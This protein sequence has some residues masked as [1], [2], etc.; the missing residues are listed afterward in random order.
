MF[1]FY[2]QVPECCRRLQLC[3]RHQKPWGEHQRYSRRHNHKRQGCENS[4]TK[5]GLLKVRWRWRGKLVKAILEPN[6]SASTAPPSVS[7]PKHV[8]TEFKM[9]SFFLKDQPLSSRWFYGGTDLQKDT[10]I[11]FF[12]NFLVFSPKFLI[13]LMFLNFSSCIPPRFPKI[14]HCQVIQVCK[15]QGSNFI[16]AFIKVSNSNQTPLSFL[17][18]WQNDKRANWTWY[19]AR[20]PA[21]VLIFKPSFNLVSI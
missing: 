6:L 15:A 21:L 8:S 18:H 12:F 19:Q 10:Y 11:C 7:F 13:T 14:Q 4:L 16:F 3:H 1:H 5:V 17:T 9:L 20:C 2:A